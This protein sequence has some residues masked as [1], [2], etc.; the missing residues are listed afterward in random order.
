[1]SALKPFFQGFQDV[2]GLKN[3]LALKSALIKKPHRCQA[4]DSWA[5]NPNTQKKINL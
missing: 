3:L 4:A 2:L 1:M 5:D